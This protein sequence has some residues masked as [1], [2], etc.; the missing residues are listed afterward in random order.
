MKDL[1]SS[2]IKSLD[3]KIIFISL[4]LFI[5]AI[6]D[7]F[8]LT[9]IGIILMY[10]FDFD[11]SNSNYI[12]ISF[13]IIDNIGI[14]E[15]L[16]LMIMFNIIKF[17]FSFFVIRKY[18]SVVINF[19]KKLA[20]FL[21]DSI[22]N[23]NYDDFKSKNLSVYQRDLIEIKRYG[24]F[25]IS[26]INLIKEISF[27]SIMIIFFTLNGGYVVLY[28]FFLLLALGVIYYFFY[29]NILK[30]T[31]KNLQTYDEIKFRKFN[32]GLSSFKE[33]N[34]YKIVKEF[35]ENFAHHFSKSANEIFRSNVISAMP[36]Y[37]FEVIILII[38]LISCLLFLNY[39]AYFK[40]IDTSLFLISFLTL[41]RLLPSFSVITNSINNLNFN[42]SAKN[43]LEKYS[44][45]NKSNSIV[46]T[47]DKTNQIKLSN[48]F[49]SY[50]ENQILSGINLDLI[51]NDKVLI[52]GKSGSGK[53][54]FIN[55]IMGF[56]KPSSGKILINEKIILENFSNWDNKLS[57]VSQNIFIFDKNIYENISLKDKYTDDE[58]KWMDTLI[59]E[60]DLKEAHINH[61]T[62]TIG[63]SGNQYSGGQ[64]QRIALARALFRKPSVLIC[65]EATNS[66]D[67]LTENKIIKFINSQNYIDILIFIS[68]N[69]SLKNQFNKV[70]SFPIK[71]ISK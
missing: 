40:S 58:K 62:K 56:L 13:K 55:L 3:K 50:N 42:S 21:F 27:I 28:G 51:K 9:S 63:Y 2:F 15:I 57:Y 6:I 7:I 49:F 36:R 67:S 11:K 70:L 19:E 16:I 61:N 47:L 46:E 17:L 34:L 71:D 25:L 4:L 22:L 65:D 43:L 10:L 18:Y 33:I 14:V 23:K 20:K 48:I 53:T 8:N 32:E 69:Q 12:N 44:Y 1:Q 60:L 66:L 35:S 54:T 52:S 68:H 26:K 24:N 38:I 29:K 45:K 41:L 5:L 59:Y 37:I 30:R 64:L 31:G 39:E